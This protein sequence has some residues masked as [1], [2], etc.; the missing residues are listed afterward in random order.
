MK[1]SLKA[2]WKH[3]SLALLTTQI[4]NYTSYKIW[5]KL[6]SFYAVF[7]LDIDIVEF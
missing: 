4:I 5:K 3:K 7:M 6:F 1:F 2:L